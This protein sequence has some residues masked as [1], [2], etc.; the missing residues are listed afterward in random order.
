MKSLR[1]LVPV[2]AV[3][4]ALLVGFVMPA[5]AS[6]EGTSW[7]V[8][9]VDIEEPVEVKGVGDLSF[10]PHYSALDHIDCNTSWEGLIANI[11]DRPFALGFSVKIAGNVCAAYISGIPCTF[12]ASSSISE[13]SPWYM[14]GSIEEYEPPITFTFTEKSCSPGVGMGGKAVV[15]TG[16]LSGEWSNKQHAIVFNFADGLQMEGAMFKTEVVGSLSAE[17]T[18]GGVVTT[19]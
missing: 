6:A 4:L 1:K 18:S 19:R 2:L 12:N 13:E 10:R 15:L 17:T 16:T 11:E 14:I 9:G 8:N 7:Q 5:A 3:A